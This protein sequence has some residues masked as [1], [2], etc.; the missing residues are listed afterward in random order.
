MPTKKHVMKFLHTG[1][2]LFHDSEPIFSAQKDLTQN[3]YMVLESSKTQ[4][5]MKTES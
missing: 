1:L 2:S 3:S 4:N 5:L